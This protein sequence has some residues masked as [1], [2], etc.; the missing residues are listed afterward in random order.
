MNEFNAIISP[1]LISRHRATLETWNLMGKKI[2]T[3]RR[4][5][6]DLMFNDRKRDGD[7][8]LTV[9]PIMKYIIEGIDIFS[10]RLV[11]LP[12]KTTLVV[13]LNNNPGLQFKI[14]PAK[15]REVSMETI[16]EAVEKNE[17][18]SSLGREPILFDD[19]ISLTEQVNKLNALE[20]AKA[21]AI[22]E[23]MLNQ[24]KLL[25]DLN[26]IH[27][28]ECDKYYNELGTPVTK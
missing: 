19:L 23:D 22:A 8:T 5:P 24:A 17:K 2:F 27:L 10:N 25:S 16:T 7:V 9:K 13:E 15:F 6:A 12:D 3:V 28:T 4:E 18:N 21:E 11:L 1:E 14:G 26:D 20:K